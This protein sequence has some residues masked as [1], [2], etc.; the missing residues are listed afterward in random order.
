[1]PRVGINRE[2]G[3]ILVGWAHVAQSISVIVQTLIGERVQ[4]R[5]F[6]SLVPALIDR[7]SN[8]ET[9]LEFIIAIAE[10]LEARQMAHSIYGEPDFKTLAVQITAPNPG[11]IVIGVV[12]FHYENG[13][14]TR[15]NVLVSVPIS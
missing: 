14:S 11:E 15:R 8:D 10:A 9:I 6:G 4:R 13:S 1:M 7:P 12:G 3:K 5:D 2:N